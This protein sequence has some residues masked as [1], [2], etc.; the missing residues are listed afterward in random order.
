MWFF[1][2]LA[3]AIAASAA[4]LL[5]KKD[6]GR[7]KLGF[8]S[9]MLWGVTLMVFV[10]HFIAF[11]EGEPFVAAETDGLVGSSV[12]LGILMLVPV[13]LVWA[14]AAFAGS[15]GAASRAD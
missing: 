11:S 14:V 2:S 1:V 8:L 7:F 15:R 4:F 3:A 13:F 10:D 5:L 9:L 6:R 12:F